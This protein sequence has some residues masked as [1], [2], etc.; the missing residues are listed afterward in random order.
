MDRAAV[1]VQIALGDFER[2][3]SDLQ[4]F[5]AHLARGDVRRS[6]GHHRL[7]AVRSAEAERDCGGVAGGDADVR[8]VAAELLGHDLREHGL[9]ALPHGGG[10]GR[11]VNPAQRI[12]AHRDRLE[13]TAP[14]ALHEIGDADA[15]IAALR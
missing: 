2:V 3:R 1:D 5:L 6:A 8:H 15:D 13:R 4:R 9:S 12:D 10:A 14:G 7:A 11:D